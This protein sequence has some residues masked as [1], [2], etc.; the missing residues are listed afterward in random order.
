MIIITISWG[1]TGAKP[2]SCLKVKSAEKRWEEPNHT[3][4]ENMCTYYKWRTGGGGRVQISA[5][6][7]W[8]RRMRTAGRITSAMVW[9]C[10]VIA[11]VNVLTVRVSSPP[12]GATGHHWQQSHANVSGLILHLENKRSKKAHLNVKQTLVAFDFFLIKYMFL[13]FL[14]LTATSADW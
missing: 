4:I 2:L 3:V 5:E 1:N 12:Q 13:C 14:L 10:Y 7:V 9:T 11:P 6:G 8:S